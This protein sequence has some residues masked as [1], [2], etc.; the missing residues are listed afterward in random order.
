M[1]KIHILATGGTIS[2]QGPAG[3]TAGYQDGAFDIG[4]L[5]TGVAGVENLAQLTGEQI[6]T[7]SSEDMTGAHWL[8]LARRINQLAAGDVDGFVITHGTNTMEE[9]AYFLHLTV[10]TDKPVV[11]TGSMRPATANSAD[12]AQNLYE[13]IALASSDQARGK[14]VL[15]AFSDGI[16]GARGVQKTNCFRPAAFDSRD[17]GCL[18]YL[19]DDLPVFVQVPARPHT[20][21]TPF[22]AEELTELPRVEI[23][24]FYA[25]ADPALLTGAASRAQGLVIAGAGSGQMSAAWKEAAGDLARRMPV[26]CCSRIGNGLVGSASVPGALCSM[27]LPP[28][29]AR[30]LL[31]LGLTRTDCRETLQEYFL[32]F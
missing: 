25:D 4:Q 31:S 17:F 24:C 14:G 5:L 29:K 26:V 3:R 32:T 2:A 9:T 18:G 7:I 27:T 10:K 8:T 1:K 30:I 16:Y 23:A 11:L 6:F 20:L 21:H 22:R 15:L 13:A 12:G 28:V 19:Q